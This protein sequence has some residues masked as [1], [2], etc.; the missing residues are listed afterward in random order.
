MISYRSQGGGEGE[1]THFAGKKKKELCEGFQTSDSKSCQWGS[2]PRNPP[3][4]SGTLHLANF[5]HSAHQR[6]TLKT[7]KQR[8]RSALL[9]RDGYESASTC[10]ASTQRACVL[11]LGPC[12]TADGPR[13]FHQGVLSHPRGI[14]AAIAVRGEG[15]FDNGSAAVQ[16][17][18]SRHYCCR[19][20][21]RLLTAASLCRS[22]VLYSSLTRAKIICKI[23]AMYRTGLLF[24]DHIKVFPR[25]TSI[26]RKRFLSVRERQQRDLQVHIYG[27]VVVVAG[28]CFVGLR[29]QVRWRLC[30]PRVLHTNGIS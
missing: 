5:L 21:G 6:T 3:H 14:R 12:G 22:S 11:R 8:C 26:L 4:L 17:Y 28:G 19:A 9:L 29:P 13:S 23:C 24:D 30:C 7:H 15:V 25:T 20:V 18:S 16:Q 27:G 1:R 2:R 10:A